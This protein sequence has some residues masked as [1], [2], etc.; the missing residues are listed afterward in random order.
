MAAGID[1]GDQRAV[2]TYLLS[3]FDGW[4]ESLRYILRNSDNGFI[5]RPLSVLPA[6]HTWEHVRG[7][8]LSAMPRT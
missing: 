4:D 3:M 1:L 8:T 2:R 6:P 5:N 7:V